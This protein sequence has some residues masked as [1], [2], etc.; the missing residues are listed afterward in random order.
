M[1]A[2]DLRTG[3]QRQVDHFEAVVN[4]A[5]SRT[6]KATQRLCQG[7]GGEKKKKKRKKEKENKFVFTSQAD[8]YFKWW[9]YN[10][11]VVRGAK[12]NRIAL[13]EATC[14]TSLYFSLASK[15]KCYRTESR[16]YVVCEM[17][18]QT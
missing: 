12:K 3:R 14:Y 6:A 8:E 17:L 2:L 13:I 18:W 5:N 1:H 16:S 15:S 11:S 7:V 9:T 10:L 4:R